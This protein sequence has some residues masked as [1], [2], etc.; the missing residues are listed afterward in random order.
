[1]SRTGKDEENCSKKRRDE[2]DMNHVVVFDN[3][4]RSIRIKSHFRAVS[5]LETHS[6]TILSSSKY[7]C[8][9]FS[10]KH[11]LKRFTKVVP[12]CHR[13]FARISSNPLGSFSLYRKYLIKFLWISAKCFHLLNAQ[14]HVYDSEVNFLIILAFQLACLLH[15]F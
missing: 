14:P 2:I 9:N 6:H 12:Q 8:R 13:I 11:R 5:D 15:I 4:T 3:I 10:C 1:M 7:W